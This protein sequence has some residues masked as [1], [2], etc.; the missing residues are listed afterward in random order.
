MFCKGHETVATVWMWQNEISFRQSNTWTDSWRRITYQCGAHEQFCKQGAGYE[1]GQ[2]MT[3]KT[4]ALL[5]ELDELKT[6]DKVFSV[7]HL[8]LTY[9]G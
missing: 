4:L 7:E 9:N 8:L 6:S 3:K 2:S 5:R 1:A